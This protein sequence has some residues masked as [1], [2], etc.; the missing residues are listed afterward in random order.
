VK[1]KQSI[2]VGESVSHTE[3]ETFDLGERIGRELS[4]DEQPA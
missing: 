1:G 2:H 4:G 3:R